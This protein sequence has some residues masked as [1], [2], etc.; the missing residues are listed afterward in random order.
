MS[1]ICGILSTGGAAV[2]DDALRP[3]LGPIR[4]WG[5]SEPALVSLGPVALG[6][7]ADGRN[8]ADNHQPLALPDVP[9][10]TLVAD[11]RIDDPEDLRRS[12]GAPA[13][14]TQSE[15]ELILRAYLRW[16]DAC[17]RH[18]YGAFAFALW[19]ATRGVL[20]CGRDHIGLRPL[21]YWQSR[22][23]LIFAT[24][25]E[26]VVAHPHVPERIDETA[27]AAHL[28][29]H[30]GTLLERSEYAGVLKLP[31]GHV[32]VARR[33][34]ID[35]SQYWFPER[36]DQQQLSS[37]T[38][39]VDAFRDGLLRATRA[40]V[41]EDAPMGAHVS[42][43][44]DSS[45]VA[46]L[47][48]RELRAQGR[49]LAGV[50]SWS[51][52]PVNAP[53]PEDERARVEEVARMIGAPVAYCEADA[54][55]LDADF[56]RQVELA[57]HE[58]L[59]YE[60]EVLRQTRLAGIGIILSGWGGDEMASFS[61]GGRIGELLRTRQWRTLMREAA[62]PSRRTGAG[63]VRTAW[64][65][66]RT[67]L[68]MGVGAML[69][70]PVAHT[71]RLERRWSTDQAIIKHGHHLHP[72]VPRMMR[73]SYA[74][75]RARPDMH[76]TRL[77]YLRNGH[78]TARV[79]AWAAAAARVGAE[80]RYPLLDRRLIELSLSFPAWL[81]RHNCEKRWVFRAAVEPFLPS[82]VLRDPK[83]EPAKFDAFHD[84]VL[85]L[86]SP[87]PD[88][89]LPAA[90]AFARASRHRVR[91]TAREVRRRRA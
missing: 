60:D 44:L 7:V 12:L 72:E 34:R 47:A 45:A 9:G 79:E 37:T 2:A 54:R 70:E 42:G 36:I 28:T 3:M 40:A 26:A 19:D 20:L 5:K 51:P 17:V 76:A 25:A 75:I 83:A 90:E 4:A 8:P 56:E 24:G 11:V 81:W 87:P 58:G 74:R 41:R 86:P 16:G 27:L 59:L 46:V 61:G 69:P 80:Y 89:T 31:P 33:G 10:V 73:E 53:G 65:T 68:N 23:S 38:D 13:D 6:Y 63:P 85:S 57:P 62:E 67:I 71:L 39:Y 21:H 49:K 50:F 48:D 64:R 78:L 1:G 77:T 91:E 84:L 18:L 32:L 82:S 30:F 88:P 35:Q 14:T 43:G 55:L 66:V 29:E 22:G 15:A 52:P